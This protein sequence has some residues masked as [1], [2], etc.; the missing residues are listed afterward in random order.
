LKSLLVANRG[1]VAIRVMRAAAELGIRSVAVHSEDDARCLHLY[2][3][4][5]VKPLRGSGPAAYLDGEQ[6]VAIAKET[7]CDAAHP[8]YGFLSE[9]AAFARR[10]ADAGISFVGPAPETLELLGDKAQARGLAERLG[11]PVLP[12]TAGPTTL[13]EAKGFLASLDGGAM[14]IKATAGGGGRGMRAV[15]NPDE[16]EQAFARC[17]SEAE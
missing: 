2:K 6:L 7:G 16:L 13:E 17:R 4:D 12:G 3:A 5:E 8:G 15:R 11:V 14:M 9:N 10:C 1:E